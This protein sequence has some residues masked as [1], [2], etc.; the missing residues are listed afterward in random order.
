MGWDGVGWDRVGCGG[1]NTA[2]PPPPLSLHHRSPST[3]ALPPPPLSLRSSSALSNSHAR[4]PQRT[5]YLIS[6][7]YLLLTTLYLTYYLLL[8]ILLTTY[9][10]ISYYSIS[11]I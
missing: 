5:L 4:E 8:Y 6:I 11:D 10:S 2:L 7:Y 9:Y 1:M 3:T